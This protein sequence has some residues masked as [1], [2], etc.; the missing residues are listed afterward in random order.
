MNVL[1]ID[2]QIVTHGYH[3]LRLIHFFTAGTDEVKCWTIR[4]P[5]KAPGAAG[6][7]HTDFERGFIMAEV[8]HYVDWKETG[9][10]AACKAGGKYHMKGKEYI[11]EDGDICY[12]KFNVTAE[13]KK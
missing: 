12:F 11:V 1:I 8:M 7:I 13:K 10:E 3:L 6:T 5:T 2:Q 4:E 9:S